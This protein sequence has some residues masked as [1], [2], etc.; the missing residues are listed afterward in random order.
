MRKIIKLTESEL[1]GLVKRVINENEVFD[2]RT[3]QDILD[4]KGTL[5]HVKGLYV[6]VTDGPFSE[7]NPEYLG[8]GGEVMFWNGR[9]GLVGIELNDGKY[10]NLYPRELSLDMERI[11]KK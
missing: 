9:E 1:I 6:K 5:S 10:V 8:V 3:L 4:D 2:V 11:N 7:K